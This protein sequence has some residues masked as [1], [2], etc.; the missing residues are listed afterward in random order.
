[1][2]GQHAVIADNLSGIEERYAAARA[3]L[4]LADAT[5]VFQP[6]FI[7]DAMDR[8]AA[9]RVRTRDSAVAASPSPN[10]CRCHARSLIGRCASAAQERGRNWDK[11][12]H[13]CRQR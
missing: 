2:T 9:I 12:S 5:A 6:I 8:T 1:M 4:E 3:D 13:A 7:S 10:R 11:I